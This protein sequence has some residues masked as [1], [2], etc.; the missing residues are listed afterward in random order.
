MKISSYAVLEGYFAKPTGVAKHAEQM[1]WGLARTSGFD[2]ELLTT[3][4][5]LNPNGAVPAGHPLA[6]LPAVG[7][8]Y[9]RQRMELMWTI[10]NRPLVDSWCEGADWIYTAWDRLVPTKKHRQ[11][12]TIH[13]LYFIDPDCPN[14]HMRQY[15]W[16]RLRYGLVWRRVAQR[17]ELVL[18]VSEFLRDQIVKWFGTP[19]QRVVVVG[20]GAEPEY[21]AVADQPRGISGRPSHRPYVVCL[22]GLNVLDG[23]PYILQVARILEKVDPSITILVVG[24]Q[25]EPEYLEQ[26]KDLKNIEFTGYVEKLALAKLM[27]DS[28]ALLFLNRYET[29]GVAVAE[30]M[31]A[32]TPVIGTRF[33]AVPEVVG[34]AGLLMDVTK[35]A[36]IAQQ[37]VDFARSESLRAVYIAKGYQRAKLFTWEACLGRLVN[38]LKR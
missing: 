26:A 29:F 27:H 4:D 9:R 3:R 1:L 34:D 14:Y 35:P 30:A 16:A 37:V 23:A 19:P 20:N 11:A 36:E 28:V 8:P 17:A 12:V 6:G 25:N 22:S 7:L 18:T 13:S 15:K 33:T 2:L 31:A 32:G 5:Q 24:H 10:F 38:A 21:F